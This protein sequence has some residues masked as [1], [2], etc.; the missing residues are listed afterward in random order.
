MISAVVLKTSARAPHSITSPL[1]PLA[2]ADSSFNPIANR[3]GLALIVVLLLSLNGFWLPLV[4]ESD[5]S[6]QVVEAMQLIGKHCLACH[7]ADKA[8]GGMI[9]DSREAILLG[10]DSGKVA[11]PGDAA[12]SYLLETLSPESE[13]HMPPRDQLTP[14][15]IATLEQ[16]INQ[17][18]GWDTLALERAQ[19]QENDPRAL[20]ALPDSYQPVLAGA[21]SGTK[22]TLL[23]SQ[24]ANLV[25]TQLSQEEPRAQYIQTPHRDAIRAVV[26]DQGRDHWITG[27]F[28]SILFWDPQTKE[29]IDA[30]NQGLQGR[31]TQLLI[32]QDQSRLIACESQPGWKGSI[33]VYDLATRKELASWQ[34]H[35]DEIFDCLETT[36]GNYWLSASADHTIK[37]WESDTFR[38]RDWLEGHTAPVMALAVNEDNSLWI[39]AGNDHS[40]KV[41]ERA[42]AEKL[43]DLGRQHAY[44]LV[45]LAWYDKSSQLYAI[46]QRGDLYSY[47]ELQAHSGAQ[48]SNTGRE[49]LM[50]RSQ[51]P[52]SCLFLWPEGESI[53]CGTFSG[54][55]I[56]YDLEGKPRWEQ[57]RQ[58]MPEAIQPH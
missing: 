47:R 34:A 18:M 42:S 44:S 27:G 51:K 33:H 11:I 31:I 38:E 54:E 22:G 12:G 46:N 49:K 5:P 39:S 32:S 45:D 23:S 6:D 14:E 19:S 16:W 1:R 7:H 24:G 55:L 4:A 57:A 41:W 25:L 58:Q 56:A 15:A 13:T 28:A 35:K 48:S 20:A 29:V 53:I 36:D 40:I 21:V 3:P 30:I 10:S 2:K 17:G 43:Y 37:V 50:V 9:M 8:K 26:V 52:A